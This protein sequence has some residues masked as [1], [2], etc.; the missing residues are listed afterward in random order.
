MRDP[1]AELTVELRREDSR[2]NYNRVFCPFN[3]PLNAVHSNKSCAL[4]RLLLSTQRLSSP[5]TFWNERDDQLENRDCDGVEDIGVHH[6]QRGLER[7]EPLFVV[8][9]SHLRPQRRSHSFKV[10]GRCREA[11][12]FEIVASSPFRAIF[13]ADFSSSVDLARLRC[14]RSLILQSGSRQSLG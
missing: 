13:D 4:S 6:F 11:L 3:S 14:P 9:L 7:S 5:L 12:T 2:V 1:F 8:L 10:N